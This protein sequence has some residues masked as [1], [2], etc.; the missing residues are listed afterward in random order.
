[1][2]PAGM[3]PE[4][5]LF[6]CTHHREPDDPL[7]AGCDARGRA[8]YDALKAAVA[9]RGATRTTWVTRAHCLGVCPKR[10]ATVAAYGAR[11]GQVYTEVEPGSAD[12]LLTGAE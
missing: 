4:L 10:G 1:M 2:R 6:V 9:T 5:H 7:G 12:A 3:R 8:V 11:D